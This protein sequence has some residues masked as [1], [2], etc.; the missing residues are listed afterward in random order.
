LVVSAYAFSAGA[1]GLLAAGF[2]DKY[3][4]KKL[5]LFFYAGFII[6]TFFCGIANSYYYLLIARV[7]TGIF[8]GVMSSIGFAIIIDLFKL[9]IRGRVMGFTQMAFAVSQVLGIPVG[10]VLA[11][12]FGWK[13]PF[14]LIA[15]LSTG[16]AIVVAIKLRPIDA[17]LKIKSD[18]NPF[19]HLAK[20]ISNPRY[21]VGFA[22]T[23]FLAIGGYMLMPFGS[24]FSIHNLGVTM[25]E[26]PY[27]FGATGIASMICGPLIGKYSDK[28]GKYKVFVYGSLLTIVM[29]YIYT[30]LGISPLWLVICVNVLLFVS[31]TTR[32]I[33]SSVLTSGIP[34]L[35]DRGAFMSINSSIQQISGG[36]GA[37]IAGSIVVQTKTVLENYDVIGYISM[38]GALVTMVL[39]YY[40]H[41]IIK[42]DQ[43]MP[44][45]KAQMVAQD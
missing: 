14:L 24:A 10:L 45:A 44:L 35:Q 31:V 26:L 13:S 37:A 11:N 23:I 9:E 21:L 15:L 43:A 27:V 8:G 22:G 33:T 4:R 2:A 19:I 40:V 28:V 32:I 3:D 30:N 25:E 17:H 39:L 12:N 18:K 42:K 41:L 5:L 36:I 29:V 1:S 7:I 38:A 34:E 20:T 16:V 6:G